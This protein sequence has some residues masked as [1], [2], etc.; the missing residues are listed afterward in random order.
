MRF[1]ISFFFGYLTSYLIWGI[2]GVYNPDKPNEDDFELWSPS[3][4]REEICL[5]GRQVSLAC[6][7]HNIGY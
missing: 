4:E 5:F 6:F 2:I 1:F 3:I 7:Y